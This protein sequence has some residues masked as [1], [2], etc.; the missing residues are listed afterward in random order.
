M[1]TE[2]VWIIGTEDA[3]FFKI[4]NAD[5]L[6][7]RMLILMHLGCWVIGTEDGDFM[8]FKM[9]CMELRMLIYWNWLKMLV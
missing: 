5:L 9:P 1:G 4:E 6:V 8:V 2:E 3:G 7:L